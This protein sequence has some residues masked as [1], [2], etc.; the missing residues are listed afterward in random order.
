MSIVDEMADVTTCGEGRHSLGMPIRR[1]SKGPGGGRFASGERCE[2]IEAAEP[3]EAPKS[4]VQ[5]LRDAQERA[6][7]AREQYERAFAQGDDSNLLEVLRLFSTAL[8]A[9]E[10]ERSLRGGASDPQAASPCGTL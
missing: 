7:Q 5:E 10:Q 6:R 3:I 2:E 1:R 9:A 4:E 8:E